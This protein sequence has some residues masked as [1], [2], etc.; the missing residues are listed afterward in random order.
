[1]RGRQVIFFA[2]LGSCDRILYM[3]N[4]NVEAI[5]LVPQGCRDVADSGVSAGRESE[6]SVLE[7]E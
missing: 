4:I 3:Y 2:L 6:T 1:V 7:V 5:L